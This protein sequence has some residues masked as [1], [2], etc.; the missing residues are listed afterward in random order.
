MNVM[1][2]GHKRASGFSLV[3]LMVALVLGLILTSGVISVYLTS[4]KTYSLSNAVGQVQENG[5]SALYFME[6]PIRMAGYMGCN[7]ST[8]TDHVLGGAGSATLDLS[9]AVEGYEANGTA[10]TGPGNSYT[11]SAANLA[12]VNN[13]TKWSP[14]LPADIL[15]AVGATAIPGSDIIVL[16]EA[17]NNGFGLVSP[18]QTSA[19]VFVLPA[20]AAQLAVGEIAV[21]TDCNKA[22]MFQITQANSSSGRVDHSAGGTVPGNMTNAQAGNL[23]CDPVWC[24]TFGASAKLLFYNSYAFYI[25]VGADGG[26]SLYQINLGSNAVNG[27]FGAPQELVSGVE[28]MQILYGIDTDGDKIPNNFQPAS[29]VANWTQ[30]V[31]VRIAIITRSDDASLDATPST[32][33][34]FFLLG[35]SP[36]DATNGVT[37]TSIKDRRL[38]KVYTETIGIRNLLN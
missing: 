32:A 20:N 38:R 15:A 11:I 30:V 4:K 27:S 18:Y 23:G 26:P 29:S 31:C 6:D 35:N 5:R 34:S 12:A 24:D 25:G 17:S 19:G 28:N 21:M 33:P 8:L 2:P 7:H 16:H 3:E 22:D 37:I 1:T 36:T 9:K 13:A 10:G 14:N